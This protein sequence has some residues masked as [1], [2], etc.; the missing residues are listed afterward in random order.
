M[1]YKNNITGII[2]AGGK[3]SRMGMDK[4]LL[5]L[6]N[7]PFVQYSIDA[8]E[9]LVNEILIVSDNPEYDT[10]GIKRIN[11]I[12]K[13]S[14]PVAGITSGLEASSTTHNLVLSCDIPLINSEILKTIVNAIDETSE[15][16]QV[17]NNGKTMPLIALYNR[18]VKDTFNALLS[19]NERRLRIAVEAC[20]SKSIV[21]NKELEYCTMNI[22]T[23][24]DLKEIEDAYN[25]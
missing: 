1:V 8:L 2:L 25:D 23:K 15:I 21:L 18:Q 7:K 10:F 14:G 4:G 6:N 24:N 12:T 17:E 20:V 16:I 5:L 13:D 22:N 3:S 11:D 19:S 9:P